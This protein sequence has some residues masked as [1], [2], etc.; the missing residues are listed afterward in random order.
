M[1]SVR[2]TDPVYRWEQFSVAGENLKIHFPDPGTTEIQTEISGRPALVNFEPK[3]TTQRGDQIIFMGDA[4]VQF[5]ANFFTDYSADDVWAEPHRAKHE[6]SVTWADVAYAGCWDCCVAENFIKKLTELPTLGA[7]MT[8]PECMHRMTLTASYYEYHI[9]DEYGIH[10]S[11]CPGGR[12]GSLPVT[13]E[14]ESLQRDPI[15]LGDFT[16]EPVSF[17]SQVLST[18]ILAS[19]Y[20]EIGEYEDIFVGDN[21]AGIHLTTSDPDLGDAVDA[22]NEK[23]S[24][25]GVKRVG[26]VTLMESEAQQ[27]VVHPPSAGSSFD[28]HGYGPIIT[29]VPRVDL[30]RETLDIN[31]VVVEADTSDAALSPAFVN[32]YPY[33]R[34]TES[35]IVGWHVQNYQVQ[36]KVEAQVQ[37]IV[38]V[39]VRAEEGQDLAD[40]DTAVLALS[41]KFWDTYLEGATGLEIPITDNPLDDWINQILI[42]IVVLSVAA[43]GIYIF[44]LYMKRKAWRNQN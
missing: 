6:V 25:Y 31:T 8:I 19:N 34:Y 2:A 35:R 7:S 4:Y 20:S 23:I 28:N 10:P 21:E 18:T 1:R 44:L 33:G 42:W 38:G 27:G 36:V 43:L 9:G 39:E 37:I 11:Q 17:Y 5:Y 30:Y 3:L 22:W 40:M 41:D 12:P 13:L 14:F 29:L 16:M 15:D 26:D 32:C 24:P